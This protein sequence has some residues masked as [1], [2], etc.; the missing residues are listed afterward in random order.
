M[1]AFMLLSPLLLA[2]LGRM[3]ATTH[4]TLEQQVSQLQRENEQLRRSLQDAKRRLDHFSQHQH[5]SE[6]QTPPSFNID[7]RTDAVIRRPAGTGSSS[8]NNSNNSVQYIHKST[9]ATA[10]PLAAAE[11]VVKYLGAKVDNNAFKQPT[12]TPSCLSLLSR[13]LD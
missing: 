2:T 12:H 3:K 9:Y 7:I 5:T 10:S 1:A 13:G 8:N 11:F 6:V 4:T